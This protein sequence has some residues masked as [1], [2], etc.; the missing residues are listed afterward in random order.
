MFLQVRI[1]SRADANTRDG[2]VKGRGRRSRLASTAG[3]RG[4]AEQRAAPVRDEWVGRD[5]QA[6]RTLVN[7]DIPSKSD[8]HVMKEQSK[9]LSFLIR[10]FA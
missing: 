7:V 1:E 3:R 9:V 10:H 4:P 8:L 2:N 6:R 5:R